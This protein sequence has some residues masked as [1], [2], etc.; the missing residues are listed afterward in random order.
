[1]DDQ[2]AISINIDI[3]TFIYQLNSFLNK[4]QFKSFPNKPMEIQKKHSS[5]KTMY[6]DHSKFKTQ[7]QQPNYSQKDQIRLDDFYKP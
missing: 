6:S 4:F 7:E 1:M 2:Y 3:N 5:F